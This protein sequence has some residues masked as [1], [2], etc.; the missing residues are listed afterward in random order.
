[1]RGVPRWFA[2]LCVV[3]FA[4]VVCA[5]SLRRALTPASLRRNS[6]EPHVLRMGHRPQCAVTPDS[7][8]SFGDGTPD[9]LRLQILPTGAPFGAGLRCWPSR[10]TTSASFQP[11]STT[12]P[13]C[14]ASA[15]AKPCAS[16]IPPGRVRMS[17]PV[18]PRSGEV[19][20]YHYPRT[21]RW[22]PRCFGCR[23]E[24]SPRAT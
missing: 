13:P 11:R 22:E 7:T 18:P 15:I 6:R 8:D 3:A 19:R 4:V 21:L 12:A 2:V 24:A 5:F 9:F 1:M 10:N 16:M 20:Q 17:L 14:C 23:M